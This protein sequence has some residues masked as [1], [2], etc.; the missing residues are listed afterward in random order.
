MAWRYDEQVVETGVVVDPRDLMLNVDGYAREMN[1][2]LDRDNVG[3]GQVTS[4]KIAN[5]SLLFAGSNPQGDGYLG[6]AVIQSLGASCGQWV[7]ITSLQKSLG[8]NDGEVIVDAD[9]N[10]ETAPGILLTAPYNNKWRAKLVVDGVPIAHTD[11]VHEVR[12]M[13]TVSMTGSLPV[14]T[15]TAIAQ[16]FIQNYAEPWTLIT[17]I[18]HGRGQKDTYR[19]NPLITSIALDVWTGNIVMV[20]RRH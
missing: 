10:V 6:G 20:N 12:R 9:V 4:A 2:F 16:V 17:A 18:T 14:I 1:G 15:G 5:L 13:T 3:V 19:A 11:W 7:E 8:V